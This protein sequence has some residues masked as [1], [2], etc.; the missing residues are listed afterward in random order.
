FTEETM[1]FPF[2]KRAQLWGLLAGG[3]LLSLSAAPAIA[4]HKGYLPPAP[5][6]CL[7]A[8]YATPLI[9]APAITPSTPSDIP[10]TPPSPIPEPTLSPGTGLA[11]G[12]ERVALPALGYIASA[13]PLT[14]FRFPYHA[15]SNH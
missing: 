15:A 14:P 11:F 5:K 1:R 3:A 12:G 4:Q 2:L 10:P 13:L 9:E 6:P 7:P 8:P